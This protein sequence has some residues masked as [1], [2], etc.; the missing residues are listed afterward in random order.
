MQA[1]KSVPLRGEASFCISLAHVARISSASDLASLDNPTDE[2]ARQSNKAAIAEQRQQ[3]QAALVQ[4]QHEREEEERLKREFEE[5]LPAAPAPT[6]TAV[7]EPASSGKKVI[8]SGKA[9]LSVGAW[10]S[11]HDG[12]QPLLAKLA[13][14]D[15]EKDTYIFV[16]RKGKK[17]RDLSK[18]ELVSLIDKGLAEILEA[19]SNFKDEDTHARNTNK[20]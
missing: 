1:G 12:D 2:Q 13:A 17:M 15:R 5:E 18:P 10:L 8:P 4:V 11:F 3:E 6:P 9:R 19:Q 7:E 20:E 14:H 16:N